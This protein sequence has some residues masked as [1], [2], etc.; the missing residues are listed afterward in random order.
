LED[1]ARGGC[2]LANDGGLF[3]LRNDRFEL[4]TRD[5]IELAPCNASVPLAVALLRD[6]QVVRLVNGVASPVPAVGAARTGASSLACNQLNVVTIAKG[7]GRL[8]AWP[9]AFMPPDLASTRL[10]R[11]SSEQAMSCGLTTSETIVCS[12]R[13]GMWKE[14]KPVSR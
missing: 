11:M 3:C 9:P 7:D 8:T 10:T 1:N 14:S 12:A 6:G 4:V 5:V 13:P 2:A